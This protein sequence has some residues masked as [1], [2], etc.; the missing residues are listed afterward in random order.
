MT[1][2]LKKPTPV[3][4]VEEVST[5]PDD[6]AALIDELGEMLPETQKTLAKMKELEKSLAPYKEKLKSLIALVTAAEGRD[7]DE[8]FEQAG[9]K[10]VAAVGKQVNVRTVTDAQLAVKLLNKAEK[11]IGWKLI[12]VPLG[13]LDQYLTPEER[14]QVLKVDRGERSVTITKKEEDA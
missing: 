1:I 13:K 2:V 14:T 7:P 8:T 6:V 3:Q 5:T 11:G 9:E 12:S 10:F 4:Q